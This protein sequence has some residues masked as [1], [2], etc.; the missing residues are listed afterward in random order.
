MWNMSDM[1]APKHHSEALQDYVKAVYRLE[2]GGVAVSTNAL[3]ENLGVTPGSV[4]AMVRRLATRGLLEHTPYRGVTL[5]P[6][7]EQVALKVIRRHRLLETFLAHELGMPWD[8][9]HAEAEV[10]EHVLSDELEELIA[11]KLGH[12]THDPH[13]DPIPSASLQVEAVETVTLADGEPGAHGRFIRISDTQPAM[14]RHLAEL[15]VAPGDR[16]EIVERQ[17]FGGSSLVRF[18][19]AVHGFGPQLAEAM[20][21]TLDTA[22]RTRRRKA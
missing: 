22:P 18:G 9:V 21:V 7:G 3:A 11:A 5:T 14:L 16:F 8:R 13:G 1:S 17:P 2:R 10:L 4:S 15:G 12:P 6:A 19:T 20:H